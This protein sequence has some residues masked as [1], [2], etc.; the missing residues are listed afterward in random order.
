MLQ[1]GIEH[2]VNIKRNEKTQDPMVSQKVN[3]YSYFAYIVSCLM[4]L[5]KAQLMLVDKGL[6]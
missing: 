2:L 3:K 1:K 5:N 6:L 4:T